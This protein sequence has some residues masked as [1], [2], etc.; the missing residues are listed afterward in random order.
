MTDQFDFDKLDTMSDEE[1]MAFDFSD[2]NMGVEPEESDRGQEVHE[3]G[4]LNNEYDRVDES[5]S[6]E[7]QQQFEGES[8]EGESSEEN[9]EETDEEHDEGS[10]EEESD[11]LDYKSMYDELL[12][13]F[14]A[15]GQ[16]MSVQSVDE[17][18]RLM[19]MG[20]NY[21]KK[22]KTL[23]PHL[24]T[25]KTLE[26]HGLLDENKLN[27]LIELDKKEPQAIQKL[28]K[29][30]EIDP[31]DIDLGEDAGNYQAGNHH[32][33]SENMA[34]RSV[35]DELKDESGFDDMMQDI[36]QKFDSASQDKI[37]ANPQALR[38]MHQHQ[39]AGIY[40]KIRAEVARRQAF[41]TL[42]IEISDFDAYYQ[43]G[44]ELAQKGAFQSD[45]APNSQPK[46]QPQSRKSNQDAGVRK[47]KQTAA[48]TRGRKKQTLNDLDLGS[49]SDDEVL[50]ATEKFL[51]L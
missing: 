35:I 28:L 8:E 13:P 7:D 50:K 45:T 18:R 11:E 42:P 3:D 41:G 16:D 5:G 19:S 29:D 48:P 15:N 9:F 47:R 10:G 6:E 25:I 22:M 49:M 37:M 14:R 33:S 51:G 12:A 36:T 23:N 24:K 20:A 17:A 43:V 39:Q 26:K 27:F 40:D 4:E 44:T 2:V 34:L 38:V 1:V 46:P 21:H 30:S 32:V 31:M